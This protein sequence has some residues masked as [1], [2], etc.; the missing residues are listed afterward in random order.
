V[1]VR[2]F[3]LGPAFWELAYP[4]QTHWEEVFILAYH[5]KGFTYAISEMNPKMRTWMLK[6]LLKERKF[7]AG[8]MRD[9]ID[10][11]NDMA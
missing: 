10:L 11:L 8:S 2:R 7:E 9:E 5:V 3:F 1:G 4:E 6:R